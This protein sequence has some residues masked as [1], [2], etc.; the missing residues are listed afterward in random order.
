MAFDGADYGVAVTLDTGLFPI[1]SKHGCRRWLETRFGRARPGKGGALL[2][3]PSISDRNDAI[4]RLLEDARG[5]IEDPNNWT[6][7]KYRSFR[8]R[9]CAVGAL[10][11]ASMR[12]SGSVPAGS[13]HELLIN[14]A[15]ARGFASVA[16]MNDR[17]S[18][19]AVLDAF[20]QAIALA[21]SAALGGHEA[22]IE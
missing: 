15:K 9:Y 12:L 21:Q 4:V 13:A 11:A 2:R 1:W 22:A 14:V 8:G 17:S 16:S 10:R 3:T 5:L 19:A 7:G 6:R 20:D 18:H